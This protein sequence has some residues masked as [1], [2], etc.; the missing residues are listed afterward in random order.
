LFSCGIRG[1][2]KARKHDKFNSLWFVPFWIEDVAAKFFLPQPPGWRKV[3]VAINE[4][5]L[6][7]FF[8]MAISAISR[9][10]E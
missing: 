3:A 4:K 7:N 2:R 6:K 1:K 8:L 9:L 10:V 5:I